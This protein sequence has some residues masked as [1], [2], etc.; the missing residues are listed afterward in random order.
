MAPIREDRAG[1]LTQVGVRVE[2]PEEM[3]FGSSVQGEFGSHERSGW[4]SGMR[5]GRKRMEI[6]PIAR[7]QDVKDGV[8]ACAKTSTRRMGFGRLAA[9]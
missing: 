3:E 6:G 5:F 2:R 7:A 8:R 1:E 9:C 4:R